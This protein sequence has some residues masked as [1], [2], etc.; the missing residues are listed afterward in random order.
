[1][2]T[3]KKANKQKPPVE[4]LERREIFRKEATL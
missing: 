1:M 2:N 4:S 3:K